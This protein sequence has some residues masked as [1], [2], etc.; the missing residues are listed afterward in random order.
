MR[1][2]FTDKQQNVFASIVVIAALW[3]C[4]AVLAWLLVYLVTFDFLVISL[5][6]TTV[7]RFLCDMWKATKDIW[8][9]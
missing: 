8:S 6:V 9:A 5:A 2:F 1:D 7:W 3:I 4:V